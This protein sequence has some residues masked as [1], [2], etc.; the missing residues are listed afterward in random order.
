VVVLLVGAT[1]GMVGCRTKVN[2]ESCFNTACGAGFTCDVTTERCLAGDGGGTD[3]VDGGGAEVFLQSPSGPVTYT[4]KALLVKV[5]VAPGGVAP[6]RVEILKD[7]MTVIGTSTTP[8]YQVTWDTTRE[9]EG[10]YQISARALVLGTTVR[11]GAVTVVVDRTAPTFT[12]SPATG[13]TNV[14]LSDGIHATFSE[15]LD[16]KTVPAGSVS[17]SAG[18]TTVAS[19]MSLSSDASSIAITVTDRSQLTFPALL[20]VNI[21]S[22]IADRAGNL[23]ASGGTWSWTAPQW[24]S[25]P[26]FAGEFPSVA[27]GPD[28]QP[29]LSYLVPPAAA[30]MVAIAKA[31][32]GGAWDV[33]IPPPTS[34]VVSGAMIALAVDG[35]P[36]V[37][38]ASDHSYVARWTGSIWDASYGNVPDDTITGSLSSLAIDPAGAPV[39]AWA[40]PTCQMCGD[41]SWVARWSTSTWQPLFAA[42]TTVAP[43]AARLKIDSAG[44]AVLS[45]RGTS[46]EVIE[47]Y[48]AGA[49][50]V[51]D[52]AGVRGGS[53]AV[54]D[55]LALDSLDR[56]AIVAQDTGTGTTSFS[57]QYLNAGAW[58][59]LVAKPLA[60]SAASTE[61]QL[62]LDG[63]D[64]PTLVWV[65][66]NAASRAE[67]IYVARWI[68]SDW[69]TSYG[70]VSGLAGQN[71]NARSV[72]MVLDRTGAPIIAWSESDG[73]TTNQTV[74]LYRSNR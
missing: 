39:V 63:T 58:T 26:S 42:T 43:G 69:D 20:T 50:L 32:P 24:V 11:T 52:T 60:F 49:W 19:S 46:A 55:T 15:P 10:S 21:A 3:A 31:T 36:F 37:G 59:D 56:P 16:P 18:G 47:K 67:D 48:S 12:R 34:S 2:P 13:A 30:P 72:D 8:P 65:A 23:I 22:T 57:V 25:L 9:P 27:M 45:S 66:M 5:G 71:T 44:A 1:V 51:I 61:V 6:S 14:L 29:I 73:S 38:W 68:G 70:A 41:A 17:L 28:D 64:R 7:D 35:T 62:A 53:G 54:A 4:N 33:S 74:F 40:R